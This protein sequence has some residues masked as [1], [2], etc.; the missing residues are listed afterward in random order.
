MCTRCRFRSIFLC[1][2]LNVIESKSLRRAPQATAIRPISDHGVDGVN[3]TVE[4]KQEN[5]QK[6]PQSTEEIK[7]S[8]HISSKF[9]NRHESICPGGHPS[10]YNPVRPGLTSE[11]EF[12]VIFNAFTY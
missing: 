6:N 1:F 3:F 10:I 8:T 5:Q 11:T 9:N 2:H 12:F 7:N 4:G